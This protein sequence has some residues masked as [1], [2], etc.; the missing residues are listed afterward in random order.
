[1]SFKDLGKKARSELDKEP[2]FAGYENLELALDGD[3]ELI[4][5][6]LPEE[7][8]ALKKR[9][10][11]QFARAA[12]VVDPEDVEHQLWFA[13]ITAIVIIRSM[14]RGTPSAIRLLGKMNGK[15]LALM[16]RAVWSCEYIRDELKNGKWTEISGQWFLDVGSYTVPKK[17]MD[18]LDAIPKRRASAAKD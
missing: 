11:V 6:Y 2:Y 17:V 8:K 1:M 16:A 10:A 7:R 9:I 15:E 14:A 4:D 5:L 13:S 18:E 12:E 3:E